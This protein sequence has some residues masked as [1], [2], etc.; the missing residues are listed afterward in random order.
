MFFATT[1]C[2]FV[3]WTSAQLSPNVS[4]TDCLTCTQ[5]II[6]STSGVYCLNSARCLRSV[7]GLPVVCNAVAAFNN[8]CAQSVCCVKEI[9]SERPCSFLGNAG[10]CLR[11]VNCNAPLA[12]LRAAEG[13]KG[14]EN[15]PADR[16]CCARRPKTCTFSGAAGLCV[17]KDFCSASQ[18]WVPSAL[19]AIGCMAEPDDVQCCVDRSS[20]TGRLTTTRGADAVPST[21][22]QTGGAPQTAQTTQPQ[23]TLLQTFRTEVDNKPDCAS[24]KCGS[25]S[26]VC[27]KTGICACK[28]PS[29]SGIE[30]CVESPSQT[31]CRT[32]PCE[33]TTAPF[34]AVFDDDAY[35]FTA[36]GSFAPRDLVESTSTTPSSSDSSAP[37]NSTTIIVAVVVG[38]VVVAVFVGV[39]GFLLLRKRRRNSMREAHSPTNDGAAITM[40]PTAPAAPA[41]G[42]RSSPSYTNVL[43][44]K[45]TVPTV[46]TAQPRVVLNQPSDYAS[47]PTQSLSSSSGSTSISRGTSTASILSTPNYAS[48]QPYVGAKLDDQAL[49]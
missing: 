18:A 38:I 22:P 27:I 37:D 4:A 32:R 7:N 40:K 11:L 35:C 45:S 49:F 21:A 8:S 47:M 16:R 17:K 10:S 14:C 33:N 25:P 9:E 43:G 48:N 24:I 42:L 20:T 6:N 41:G 1:L 28:L 29:V 15:E 3:A 23:T 12:W 19:G 2:L 13:A 31:L 5:S 46:T 39:L 30:G 34:C 26:G 44:G 36:D